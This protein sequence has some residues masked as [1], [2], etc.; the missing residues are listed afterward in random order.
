MDN[1][2][3]FTQLKQINFPFNDKG[4]VEFTIEKIFQSKND[5][6]FIYK[7]NAINKNFITNY[8]IKKKINLIK[9]EMFFLT[10]VILSL[11]VQSNLHKNMIFLFSSNITIKINNTGTQNIIYEGS[12]CWFK[13]INSFDRPDYM[14]INGIQQDELK[15][16]YDFNNITNIVK[17]VW[18]NSVS[19][20]NCLFHGCINIIDIDFSEFDFSKKIS[21]NSMFYNCK[22]LTSLNLHDFGI[23]NLINTGSMF[24]KCESLIYLNL[25]NFNTVENTDMGNMFSECK[26]LTT[27]DL[28]NFQTPN[29][30]VISRI[31]ENCTKLEYINLKNVHFHLGVSTVD[32]ISDKINLVICTNDEKIKQIVNRYHCVVVDC[33]EN[34]RENQKKINLENNECV[35]NCIQT[36]NNK[37][38]YNSKCYDICPNGTYN[39][40]FICENCHSDCKTCEKS[41]EIDS[42]NCKSCSSN[43]KFL[44]FGNCVTNCSNG[45]YY[46]EIDTSIKICKCELEKCYKCSKESIKQNLCI[47]CNDGY[48][49]K[50][51]EI[52]NVNSFIDC[53]QSPE[54]YY[55]NEINGEKFYKS[56][57]KSC[58]KCNKSGNETNHNCIECDENYYFEINFGDYK[59]CYNKCSY[60]YYHD[61]KTNIY[62]CTEI[63]KCTEEY[64]KLIYNKS[65][66]IN[67]CDDDETN[68]H[69]FKNICYPECPKGSISS[70]KNPTYCES[71]C[72]EKNPFKILSNQ[73]CVSYC[74]I[75][76]IIQNLCILSVYFPND[77]KK[78]KEIKLMN[79]MLKNVEA[80]LK[81]YDYNT[82]NLENG[83]ED[84][85]SIERMTIT[86]TTT[87]NQ[88][89]NK[90][91]NVTIIDLRNCENKLREV[92]KIPDNEILYIK[93]IDLIQEG[94]RIPKIEY[95]IYYKLNKTNLVKLNLSKCGN[96]Q[97]SLAIP[98]EITESL[99]KINSTSDYF[100]DI[101]YTAKSDSG[102][103]ILLNDRKK[104]FVEKKT[105]CQDDCNFLN[106]KDDIHIVN[107]SCNAKNAS[108]MVEDM[109]INKT[110]LYGNFEETKNNIDASNL[111][112]TS[113][114]VFSNKENIESNTGFYLLLIIITI[115]IIIF[116]IFCIKGYNLLERQIDE[117]IYK[118]FKKENKNKINNINN[119]YIKQNL[120]SSNLSKK[121]RNKS[122]ITKKESLHSKASK[123]S[124]AN[125]SIKSLFDK[126]QSKNNPIKNKNIKDIKNPNFKPDTDY[127]LNWLI[128]EH[129]IKFDKRTYCDYYCS[130]IKSKQL[131]IFTFCA[132]DDYNS[133]IIK[134]FMFFLSFALHY[135]INALFFTESNLH[136]IYEDEGKFNFEYQISFISFSAIISTI[137]LRLVLKFLVL[138]DKDL[139][140]VKH[141]L[142]KD[143]AIKKKKKVLKNMK[144]KF[145]IFFILNFILLGLFWYY[146]TCFNAVFQ[147]TQIYLIENTFIS[148]ALSL[149][150]PFII[151]IIPMIIRMNSI[152][153]SKKNKKY[154]YKISQIVQII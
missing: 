35:E 147:N 30:N 141:Q 29:V 10:L 116:I 41:S 113:C 82:S 31:F 1:K 88:K 107:C 5:N 18:K 142:T 148:F 34:W 150:Y 4:K 65:E 114:N 138:T 76:D 135:T 46:D 130:L 51:N 57:Y 39:N 83:E 12:Y 121:P 47:S 78:E 62:H 64:N 63:Q 14:I 26:S 92:Y 40:S 117:I 146:L 66:C 94:M 45:F 139:V 58:K 127:E 53:Y 101:C 54:G 20:Y 50:Y 48:Y 110:K 24:R 3:F 86:L 91:N 23:I 98:I 73:E 133:G 7:N 16:K 152:K 151:N 21:A 38:N 112:I 154:I 67:K 118:K 22:S 56:C 81:S 132:F 80:G 95:D 120:N 70:E 144:I 2:N 97:I 42:T 49:P 100:T 99:D 68:K 108:S 145:A 134:K 153:S 84:I 131:F 52:N 25:S 115:F 104:E 13:I 123:A 122:K 33:S 111:G 6:S 93:K 140:E 149:F 124:K 69:E 77:N 79:I 60:Y 102:T 17:I 109:N 74:P 96:N 43:D 44:Y 72:T 15:Y 119:S 71:I 32:I 129:A 55:L 136:Q 9:K 103:D 126:K 75:K 37:Y 85:I 90:N 28:S 106:Y 11:M 36:N 8:M 59:N 87:K 19:N 128:Y 27:L 137:I 105:V 125:K 89:N 143:L 61:R